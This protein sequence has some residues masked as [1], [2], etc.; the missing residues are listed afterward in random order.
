MSRLASRFLLTVIVVCGVAIGASRLLAIFPASSGASR[1]DREA[2]SGEGSPK[3]T[4]G[5]PA[6]VLPDDLSYWREHLGSWLRD[7]VQ[8][9]GAPEGWALNAND[10]FETGTALELRPDEYS[11]RFT[12]DVLAA[13]PDMDHDAREHMDLLGQQGDYMMY[14]FSE[15]SREHIMA[16]GPTLWISLYAYSDMENGSIVWQSEDA[17]EVWIM[18]VLSE[19]QRTPPPECRIEA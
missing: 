9:V 7:I 4:P 18:N 19:V 10:I 16:A 17:P 15:G 14:F 3:R 1:S 2:L 8:R 6:C 13:P 12:I 5:T 11:D